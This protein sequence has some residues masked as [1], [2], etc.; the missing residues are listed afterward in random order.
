VCKVVVSVLIIKSKIGIGTAVT[1]GGSKKLK[2][3]MVAGAKRV[4]S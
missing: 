2:S 3:F 1:M 4:L